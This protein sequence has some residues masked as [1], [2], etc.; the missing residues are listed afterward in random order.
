MPIKN[1]DRRIAELSV[2]IGELTRDG[3]DA[4]NA[5][6]G[7][8]FRAILAQA[9]PLIQERRALRQQRERINGKNPH[10]VPKINED[11]EP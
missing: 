9:T 7:P 6:D 8:G 4:E 3:F 2:R 11:W 5:K 10:Y 1:I